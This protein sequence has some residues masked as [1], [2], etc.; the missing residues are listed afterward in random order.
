MFG[1]GR[2]REG[3]QRLT[4]TF[5]PARARTGASPLR[6]VGVGTVLA[7][8][9]I[10]VG[11]SAACAQPACSGDWE[12]PGG[13]GSV[14]VSSH[15]TCAVLFDDGS[16]E[17][18][19]VG[20]SF[21]TAGGAVVNRIARW[22][23][24]VW[25]GLS[26]PTG[27]GIWHSAGS[28]YNPVVH[29]LHVHDDGLGGGP[30]LYVGGEFAFAGGE[31]A[32]DLA[33]WDGL[34]WSPVLD[35]AGRGVNGRVYALATFDDGNGPGLYVA[36]SYQNAG[37][38]R[39][40]NIAR[41]DGN[42]W[43]PLAAGTNGWINALAV[44]DDGRGPALYAGGSISAAS[45]VVASRIARWD[46]QSWSALAD[47][48]GEGLTPAAQSNVFALAA[49]GPGAPGGGDRFAGP[50]SLFVGGWFPLAG[51][52]TA[53]NIARWDG[54][55]W[56]T[57]NGPNEV[58]LRGGWDATARGL[59][60]A[61]LD[62]DKPGETLLVIGGQFWVTGPIWARNVAVWDGTILSPLIGPPQHGTTGRVDAVLP[63]TRRCLAP[64]SDGA[65]WQPAVLFGGTFSQAGAATVENLSAYYGCGRSDQCPADANLD[66][67]LDAA[68]VLIM[69]DWLSLSNSAGDLNGDGE[70][71][72]FDL[73]AFLA[74][75]DA[76]CP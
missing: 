74:A 58:G 64:G 42:T 57:L 73:L 15:I 33:R 67:T 3:A 43:S 38:V 44:F 32:A 14:G 13:F 49:T 21:E 19:Y 63:V 65:P 7:A 20:G 28:V 46:G 50:P 8:G 62:A 51:G 54:T 75:L 4:S 69:L 27:T 22:D 40:N 76:G 31:S 5:G 72:Y 29:A 6:R 68:D 11:A 1:F 45:G 26:G 52:R 37:G 41:F 55:Q 12:V 25:S 34:G 23:G 10:E 2:W 35:G 59:G 53:N 56:H 70:T 66:G 17:A 18:V 47:A 24:H 48:H 36:G 60:F 16:G 61:A 9:L 30:A 71:D 39:V